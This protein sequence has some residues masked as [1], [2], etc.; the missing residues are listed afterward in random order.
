MDKK[1]FEGKWLDV[2]EKDGWQYVSRKDN[3][4]VVSCIA[5]T[6]DNNRLILVKQF[7]KPLNKY[8]IEFP[9]GLVD[10]G[11]DVEKA[12]IRELEEETGY[13]GIIEE[14]IGPMAK[15]AGLSNETLYTTIIRCYD[16]GEQ[17]LQDEEDIKV[18]ELNINDGDEITIFIEDQEE[19]GDVIFDSNV[20]LYLQQLM[21]AY[22]HD[23]MN[24]RN[25]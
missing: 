16:E 5:Y 23:E 19:N 24:D 22:Y 1:I 11:E 15:S 6:P 13:K 20:R 25:I 7:R 8:V 10:K 9:A 12:A 18:I 14:V 2:F 17:N 3:T 21:W 4:K